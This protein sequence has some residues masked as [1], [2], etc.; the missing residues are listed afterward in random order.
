MVKAIVYY[1]GA[2]DDLIL[3][4]SLA[5]FVVIHTLLGKMIL[6]SISKYF[7]NLDNNNLIKGE[8]DALV[9]EGLGVSRMPGTG[10]T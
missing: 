1:L 4:L 8:E 10:G 3:F 9:Q 5:T 7:G 2:K 6:S